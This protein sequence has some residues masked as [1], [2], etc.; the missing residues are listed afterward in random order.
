M[1]GDFARVSRR[2]I[3]GSTTPGLKRMSIFKLATYCQI[4]LLKG[5]PVY[6]STNKEIQ[7]ELKKYHF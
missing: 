7:I 1:S 3:S 6:D 5:L 2:E 4:A